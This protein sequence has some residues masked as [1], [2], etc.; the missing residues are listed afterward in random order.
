MIDVGPFYDEH[1]INE[2][3]ILAALEGE[4]RNLDDLRPEDLYAHDQDHYGHL[5]AVDAIAERL[6]LAS[7]GQQIL[8]VCC[9]LGGP[10]RYVAHKFDVHVQG[11]DINASR[12]TGAQRLT[13]LVGMSDQASFHQADATDLPFDDN[14]FDAT[15][16]QEAFLHIGDKAALFREL[17]R[18]LK[19]AANLCITDWTTSSGLNDADR[20]RL[21]SGF[22][23]SGMSAEAG[24]LP[25]SDHR[26]RFHQGFS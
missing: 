18:V 17:R 1:P 10:A 23:A 13:D 5:E 15:Y 12:I 16:S 4:G 21:E 26:S 2:R 22:A 20:V 14:S 24:K 19:P 3:A 25:E 9:G 7:P 8:D 11:V 6:G